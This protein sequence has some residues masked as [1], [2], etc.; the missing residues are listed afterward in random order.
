MPERAVTAA[1]A[2]TRGTITA[3]VRTRACSRNPAAPARPRRRYHRPDRTP[4]GS[5]RPH[6]RIRQSR[7]ASTKRQVTGYEPDFGSAQASVLPRA[8]AWI[9]FSE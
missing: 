6:Q 4:T 9:Q 2:S 7:L 5:R 1:M 3:T 8:P